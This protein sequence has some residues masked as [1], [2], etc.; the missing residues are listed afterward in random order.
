MLYVIL[1]GLPA[2]VLLYILYRRLSVWAVIDR[3]VERIA[4]EDEYCAMV[5]RLECHEAYL[6]GRARGQARHD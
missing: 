4:Q 6:R 1:Y 3:E 5:E 2:L